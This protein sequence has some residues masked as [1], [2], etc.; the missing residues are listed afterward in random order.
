MQYE[1]VRSN[2]TETFI[3][4]RGRERK[5]QVLQLFPFTSERKRMSIIIHDGERIRMFSK[6]ADS[7]IK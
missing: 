5:Y 3:R 2:K 4:I 7:I 1:F 6:G